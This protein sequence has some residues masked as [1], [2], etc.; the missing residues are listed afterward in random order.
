M[1]FRFKT[2]DVRKKAFSLVEVSAALIIL[3]LVSSGVMVVIDQCATSGADSMLRMQAFEVARE[4]ME[5]LLA[6]DSLKEAVDYGDSELYPGV[7]WETAVETFY[8]PITARMWVQGVCLARF[9]DTE[10][11]EQT[12]ELSHW[13][14][15]VSKDQ[16]LK[17]MNEQD[18]EQ[19][20]LAG[21]LIEAV[22]DA[23]LYAAVDVETIEQWID[24]GMLITDEGSF[25]K[26]NLD[27]YLLSNGNPS[28]EQQQR[29]VSS[30]GEI[31]AQQGKLD[32]IRA[33]GQ[34]GG[35]DEIDPKTGLTY[36]ELEQMDFSEIWN[37]MKSRQR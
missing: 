32:D 10:G 25:V 11:Q 24:N 5:K 21:Q 1:I 36:R 13:L 22:E 37:L 27:I 30:Q 17:M 26:G 15:D 34:Q 31:M 6:R 18:S 19:G 8:E 23:A 35:L 14:T 16:L 33:M 4:N 12:V 3:A 2:R 20:P 9:E 29:Q 7:K 28:P